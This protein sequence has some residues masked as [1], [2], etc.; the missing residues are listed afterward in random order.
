KEKLTK[1]FYYTGSKRY[2][3]ILK[4]LANA[5]N[6]TRH[7]RTG[8]APVN[9][10]KKNESNVFY[11]LY[12]NKLPFKAAKFKLGNRIRILLDKS[13]FEKGY[14]QRWSDEIFNVIQIHKT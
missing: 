5:Y 13:L 2:I 8:V 9:V 3:H 12:K 7:S 4:D 6:E 14:E 1:I 11:R 10:N